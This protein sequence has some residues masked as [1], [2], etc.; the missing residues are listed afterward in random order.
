MAIAVIQRGDVWE[1][2]WGATAAF[3][4]LVT[5]LVVAMLI[6]MFNTHKSAYTMA[7]VE[8]N[9]TLTVVAPPIALKSKYSRSKQL[10]M[11]ATIPRPLS[12]VK[13]HEITIKRIPPTPPPID[14]Q[15]Q[16]EMSTKSQAQ[17]AFS[18]IPFISN[19]I[20]IFSSLQQA[21]NAHHKAA[22][23]QNGDSYQSSTGGVILKVNG[24]CSEVQTVQTGPSPSDRA[25]ITFPGQNCAGEYQPTL[26][27]ELAKWAK[28]QEKKYPPP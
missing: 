25:T 24:I 2:N 27:E 22:T 10:N 21:L 3:A 18:S 11:P 16:I 28:Q 4:M 17:T 14:W 26:A 5:A 6:F 9:F 12:V 20:P 7:P 15:Q 19:R 23:M 1:P 13:L 8:Q